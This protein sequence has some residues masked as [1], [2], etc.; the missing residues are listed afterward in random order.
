[1]AYLVPQFLCIACAAGLSEG[2]QR[3]A[4]WAP[5]ST[6]S[7]PSTGEDC[8]AAIDGNTATGL[9]PSITSGRVILDLG[10]ARSINAVELWKH[11]QAGSNGIRQFDIESSSDGTTFIT[12]KSFESDESWGV[13]DNFEVFNLDAYV[14][15]RYVGINFSSNHG[16]SAYTSFWSIKVL[17]AGPYTQADLDA[18]NAKPNSEVSD[19]SWSCEAL[20]DG[21]GPTVCTDSS[22][23]HYDWAQNCPINCAKANGAGAS[24]FA[25]KHTAVATV[26]FHKQLF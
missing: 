4:I 15:A 8:A 24:K 9:H 13:D 5:P 6:C 12:A 26:L 3:A 10:S 11:S 20:L 22:V 21:K 14:V 1:M 25:P 17:S 2:L 7:V 16:N 19:G 18:E 23:P